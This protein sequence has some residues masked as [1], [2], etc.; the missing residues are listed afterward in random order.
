MTRNHAF[1]NTLIFLSYDEFSQVFRE[2][3]EGRIATVSVCAD[4]GDHLE[5]HGVFVVKAQALH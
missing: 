3:N 4:L 5:H 1:I 2:L